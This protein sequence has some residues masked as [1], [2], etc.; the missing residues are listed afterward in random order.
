M[1]TP[2]KIAANDSLPTA[3]RTV[4]VWAGIF[5]A[6]VV[7]VLSL[8]LVFS[9]PG[10]PNAAQPEPVLTSQSAVELCQQLFEEPKEYIDD[11]AR[12]RRWVGRGPLPSATGTTCAALT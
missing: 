4:V 1:V 11:A 5:A 7:A 6:L 10:Q 9:G 3:T 2:P 12:R 8:P